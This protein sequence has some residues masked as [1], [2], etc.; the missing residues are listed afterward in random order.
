MMRV[1][2]GTL[3]TPYTIEAATSLTGPL[4][5]AALFTTNLGALFRNDGQG[6]FTKMTPSEVGPLASERSGTYVASLAALLANQVRRQTQQVNGG[7]G[8]RARGRGRPY[9]GSLGGHD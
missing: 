6:H 9:G 3:G 8:R 2:D 4:A 5:W 1:D 7:A